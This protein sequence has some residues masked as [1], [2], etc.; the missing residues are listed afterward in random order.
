[1]K[2]TKGI[3]A[4]YLPLEIKSMHSVYAGVYQAEASESDPHLLSY[5]NFEWQLDKQRRSDIKSKLYGVG[6]YL[7]CGEKRHSKL[8]A[9]HLNGAL[10]RLPLISYC[11][12]SQSIMMA[13]ELAEPL[14][15]ADNLGVVKSNATIIDPALTE[16]SGYTTL[17]FFKRL[18]PER[19]EERFAC[20]A[21][22]ERPIICMRLYDGSKA[23]M[24]HRN[25]LDK[26]RSMGV[27]EVNYAPELNNLDDLLQA[28]HF[29]GSSGFGHEYY[30]LESYQRDEPH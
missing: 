6:D 8:L 7:F 19:I 13:N 22:S 23:F 28:R 24:V 20:L 5:V 29:F 16:R 25:V 15:F 21:Q 2:G 11:W 30:S 3:L 26:W 17:S 12:G 14:N 9:Q 4:Q 10:L 27:K 18:N 1:M